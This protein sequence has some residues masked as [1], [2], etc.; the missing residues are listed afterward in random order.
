MNE[1]HSP[2][3]AAPVHSSQKRRWALGAL[4]AATTA[5][6]VLS[7]S[8]WAGGDEPASRMPAHRMGTTGAGGAD[9]SGIPFGGRHLQRLL[10]D[11]KVSEVQRTQIKQFVDKAQSDLKA[12]HEEG[13]S[14]HEQGLKL[15]AAPK[16]DAVAAEKLRQQMQAHH[17]KVSK[18]MLQAMLDVGNVLTPEQRTIVA[19]QLE[20]RHEDMMRRGHRHGGPGKPGGASE[21]Q[22]VE[23]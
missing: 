12:L 18:R 5:S 8:A 10:D 2:T 4:I 15:W 3:P 21:R 23:Q 6:V 16:I 19:R 7:I 1:I 20:K 11:A 13:K 9:M 22:P 17:D 14:L